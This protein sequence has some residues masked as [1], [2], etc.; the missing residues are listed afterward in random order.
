MI[1]SRI[2]ILSRIVS[3][4]KIPLSTR[5][6]RVFHD[7]YQINTISEII[8]IFSLAECRPAFFAF[9]KENLIIS[10]ILKRLQLMIT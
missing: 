3:F 7:D 5:K 1:K 6:A 9:K 2:Q 10:M 8:E 4:I